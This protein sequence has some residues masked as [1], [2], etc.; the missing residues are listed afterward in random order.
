[1][2]YP[3]RSQY[4]YDRVP[5]RR[6]VVITGLGAVSAAGV[7]V[8]P[9][10]EAVLAN[11]SCV[12]PITLFKSV[13]LPVT[14]GGQV[15]D[16]E[17]IRYIPAA[18]RP[19]RMARHTQFAVVAAQEAIADSGR[20]LK[21][22]PN[23]RMAVI[24]GAAVGTSEVVEEGTRLLERSG[25][26]SISPATSAMGNMQAAPT[27]IVEMMDVAGTTSTSI[28]NTCSSGVDAVSMAADMIR[29]GRRDLTVAGG[30]DAPLSDVMSTSIAAAGMTSRRPDGSAAGRPFDREREGG[31]LGEGAGIVV[32]EEREMALAR[33]AM[34]YAEVVAAASCPDQDRTRPT[35]GLALTM[36]EAMESAGRQPSDID[37][38]SAWGCGD[39][40]ID[41][42]E[43][44]AIKAAMGKDAYRVAVGSI[45]GAIGIPLGA[46][47]ALQLVTTALSHSHS[48]LPPTVNHCYSDLDCDLDYVGE[49]PRRVRL[50][51]SLLNAHGMSGGNTTLLLS[52][53]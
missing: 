24:V 21:A 14:Y 42:C 3:F 10:W 50:R 34:I 30:A 7:G 46:A 22:I 43:T 12:G 4:Q 44:N 28:T 45:K 35:S 51:H 52:S 41:L 6:R 31:V 39:P 27:A 15:R 5:S 29:S 2:S 36:R 47:G 48:L 53:S 33:G 49:Q 9:L 19:K 23:P 20:T 37:Y 25:S 38:I 1:M 16:F 32:L 40:V 8:K 26:R 11:R 18:L 13:G 17:P